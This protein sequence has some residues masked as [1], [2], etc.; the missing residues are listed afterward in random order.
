MPPLFSLHTERDPHV[1]NP[2]VGPVE[3]RSIP[4]MTGNRLVRRSVSFPFPFDQPAA[5]RAEWPEKTGKSAPSMKSDDRFA[6]EPRLPA[7]PAR[8]GFLY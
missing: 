1:Q 6:E 8:S 3:R 2:D 4:T 7:I 5:A